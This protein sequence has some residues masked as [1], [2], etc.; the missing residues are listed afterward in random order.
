MI[1]I[2]FKEENMRNREID[3]IEMD[4]MLADALKKNASYIQ[5]FT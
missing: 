3:D 1:A 2:T 5:N 4:L